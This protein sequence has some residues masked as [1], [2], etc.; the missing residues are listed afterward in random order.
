MKEKRK[1]YYALVSILVVLAT[2]IT[3]FSIQYSRDSKYVVAPEVIHETQSIQFFDGRTGH[4]FVIDNQNDIGRIV[5]SL[6]KITYLDKVNEKAVGAGSKYSLTFFDQSNDQVFSFSVLGEVGSSGTQIQYNDSYLETKDDKIWEVEAMIGDLA[7][8]D[9]FEINQNL[10]KL[11]QGK[12]DVSL[13]TPVTV[14][15]NELSTEG[16]EDYVVVVKLKEGNY[17][18]SW[19]PGP[20]SGRNWKGK[21]VLQLTRVDGQVLSEYDLG[22]VF[23][24]AMIFSSGGFELKFDDYNGDG[25][26]DFTIGQY[27]SSNGR[28]FAL[29]TII[30]E[31]VKLL[32]FE[33]NDN[34]RFISDT[35][36][37]YSTNL[38]KVDETTFK[39]KYYDN[40]VPAW[41][42]NTY[43]WNGDIFVRINE[44]LVGE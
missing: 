3:I 32:H 26:M 21:F 37:Y 20:F 24:E 33:N 15:W 8:L 13:L 27:G 36:G 22:L 29:F 1:A 14:S 5:Q 18:E 41:F 11:V 16:N 31:E 35:N 34:L 40:S 12:G 43:Q 28:I 19:E 10:E 42:E 38:N 2:I 44:E 30:G 17:S 25:N 9:T 7:Y 39:V 23:K 4:T 6:S